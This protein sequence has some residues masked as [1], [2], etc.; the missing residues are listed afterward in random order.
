MRIPQR[1]CAVSFA[2]SLF[3]TVSPSPSLQANYE[4]I[5]N[6]RNDTD[7]PKFQFL[8]NFAQ[9]VRELWVEEILPLLLDQPSCL[10]LNDNAE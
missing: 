9:V 6:H 5:M 7:N 4:Y 3:L 8:P 10:P 2:C 1:R